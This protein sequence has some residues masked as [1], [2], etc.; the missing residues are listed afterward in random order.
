MS[1][2][3]PYCNVVENWLTQVKFLGTYLMPKIDVQFAATF[4]SMPGWPIASIYNTP[5]AQVGPS[6]GRPLS[7]GAANAPVNLLQ[8]GT[9]STT[10][11]TSSISGS[12][13]SCAS[14][15]AGRR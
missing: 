3:N 14:G 10:A 6:L 8:P 13:S 1:Q 11:P 15:R 12:A 7:G 2:F 5:N 9:I 4:Q